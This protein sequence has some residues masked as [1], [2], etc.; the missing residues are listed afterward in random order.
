MAP[1]MNDPNVFGPPHPHHTTHAVVLV[2]PPPEPEPEPSHHGKADWKQWA[3]RWALVA[4]LGI[5]LVAIAGLGSLV[6]AE[7]SE[8]DR[9]QDEALKDVP[10]KYQARVSERVATL[11]EQMRMTGLAILKLDTAVV[12]LATQLQAES[13]ARAESTHQMKLLV[14]ELKYQRGERR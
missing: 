10:T 6:V 13:I 12:N 1:T 4:A 11:E 14:A 3:P 9:R 2:H 8:R 5:S 7:K